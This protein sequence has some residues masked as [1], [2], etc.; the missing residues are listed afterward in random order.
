[1]VHD[2]AGDIDRR[3]LEVNKSS[4]WMTLIS[5]LARDWGFVDSGRGYQESTVRT[6][7]RICL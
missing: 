5:A 2:G 1:M 4:D 3:K 6:G 7:F